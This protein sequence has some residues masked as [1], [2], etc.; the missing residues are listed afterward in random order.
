MLYIYICE[1]QKKQL[2]SL[3]SVIEKYL[4]RQKDM[5]MKIVCATSD[6]DKVLEVVQ[7][8][9]NTGLY[10]LDIDLKSHMT[11]IDLACK[12]RQ[13]DPRGFIVFLTAHHEHMPSI[14]H[15]KLEAMDYIIKGTE[16]VKAQIQ[17]CIQ[18][19][20]NKYTIYRTQHKEQ[21]L[22]RKNNS[23][24][25]LDTDKIIFVEAIKNT[26]KI[27]IYT[28][29]SVLECYMT[30]KE[31]SEKMP[32]T[33]IRCHNSFIVNRNHIIKL[34]KSKHIIS[35]TNGYSCDVSLRMMKNI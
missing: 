4:F 8:K 1:D 34:D 12:I 18:D 13:Y 30:L 27:N 5:D 19:A 28:T 23:N 33:F 15:F 32:D 35:L 22:I 26:H 11:G 2:E 3:K 24:F 16:T 7:E 29:E 21:I 17:A 10:F 14:L 25:Y 20:W 6:P 31:I 9:K